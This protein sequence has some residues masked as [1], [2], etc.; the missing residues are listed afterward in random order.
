MGMEFK[1]PPL[2]PAMVTVRRN[3]PRKARAT[4]STTA[5]DSTKQNPSASKL[6]DIPRCPL[7]ELLH[8][9][10]PQIPSVAMPSSIPS[11]PENGN[12]ENLRVFLRIKPLID[13]NVSSKKNK[14]TETR[15][16][17]K[18][19]KNN[20]TNKKEGICLVANDSH[21]VT[22]SPPLSLQDSKRLKTEVYHGFSHVFSPDSSQKEIYEK[23]MDPLVS[24]FISGKSGMLTAMGPTG[25]GKTHTIFGCPR[26]PGIVPL[27]LRRIFSETDGS[28][29]KMSRSYYI[30]MLEIYSDRGKGERIID[31]STD[32]A[33]LCSQQL[34]NKGPQEVM[35]SD[36]VQ[37]ECV[38]ARGMLK[39]TTAM[40]NANSQSSRSQCII[41]IRSSPKM[42]SGKPEVQPS[43]AV[44]T[45]VDLAGAEREKRTGN[46]GKQ[47]LE[48]N[49][50]NNTSMVFSLCLRSLLEHQ[51]NPKKPLQK[52]FQN[53]LLTRYLRDY[54]EGKR[55]ITLILTVKP[56]EHDYLDTSYLLRQSSPYM[57]IKF[58]NI[59]EPSNLPYQKR[60]NHMLPRTEQ[61]KRRKF[62]NVDAVIHEGDGAIDKPVLEPSDCGPLSDKAYLLKMLGEY[63]KKL[64][65]SENEV[66]NLQESL[67]K[68]KIRSLELE[69]ELQDL[70]SSC[71]CGQIRVC[72]A[73]IDQSSFSLL[74]CQS[75]N[76]RS[77]ISP[78]DEKNN[79]HSEELKHL[80]VTDNSSD[81]DVTASLEH[82]ESMV[83]FSQS[84]I[85]VDSDHLTTERNKFLNEEK[86]VGAHPSPNPKISELGSVNQ[87]SQ[88]SP[89]DEKHD[90]HSEEL[91][92][93]QVTDNSSGADVTAS[94]EHSESMVCFSQST[95]LV[96]SDH[97]T[98]EQNKLLN[99]DKKVGAHPFTNLKISELGR[100]QI[101]PRDEKNNG[102]FEELKYLQVTDNFSDADITAASLEHSESMVCFSQSTILVDSDH[103]TTE[104]NKL[105]NEDKKEVLCRRISLDENVES[106]TIENI[107][108]GEPEQDRATKTEK[109]GKPRRKLQPASSLLLK[110]ISGL[111]LED[112]NEKPK[113]NRAGERKLSTGERGR[114]QGSISLLKLIRSNFHN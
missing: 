31:L 104:Q 53:S 49:F 114:S 8:D 41:H 51:K 9:D 11:P 15:S 28:D 103:L 80:L 43:C 21:S 113:G 55:R 6:K 47:L 40:T 32:G 61:P 13:T 23:V 2:C 95:I 111:N 87:R 16:K 110:E 56:G 27:T 106:T 107:A 76:Q 5:P 83:C 79:D 3:P 90:D 88:I 33:D 70:K 108:E 24:D 1:S 64:Q 72:D 38:V 50:I 12:S 39:R 68:E 29:S 4:P 37:A 81:A 82:S 101:S 35:V 86:K 52:H 71:S 46:Q 18:A 10:T 97:L 62:S 59:E 94:L 92:H 7:E 78:R 60:H 19:A 96:D 25:S 36:V 77:Q 17:L 100:S 63:K 91:K 69:R 34:T 26:E 85:L 22:L 66:F 84:T 65:E 112:E 30:S 14:A 74:D 58:N 20:D 67:Q 102:H 44:L 109:L 99:E 89:R 45:I 42:I 93:L 54:L 75:V 73:V 48:S 98:T 105:L 57:K